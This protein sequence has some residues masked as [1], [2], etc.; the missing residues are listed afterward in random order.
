VRVTISPAADTVR[1]RIFNA[2]LQGGD[3]FMG[4]PIP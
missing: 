2:R 1:A 4:E 3:R